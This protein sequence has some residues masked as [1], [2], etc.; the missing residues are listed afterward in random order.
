[1]R[2]NLLINPIT[3]QLFNEQDTDERESEF[4]KLFGGGDDDEKE[5]EKEDAPEEKGG[6]TRRRDP[7]GEDPASKAAPLDRTSSRDRRGIDLEG[8]PP[9]T[10]LSDIKSAKDILKYLEDEGHLNPGEGSDVIATLVTKAVS[11]VGLG[12]DFDELTDAVLAADA[13]Q[14]IEIL[15]PNLQTVTG[16]LSKEFKSFIYKGDGE[17]EFEGEL[18]QEALDDIDEFANWITYGTLLPLSIHNA[19]KKVNKGIIERAKKLGMDRDEILRIFERLEDRNMLSRA[20]KKI[21]SNLPTSMGGG[22]IESKVDKLLEKEGYDL[23]ENK[24]GKKTTKWTETLLGKYL[25]DSPSRLAYGPLKWILQGF[26]EKAASANV[27]KAFA[28]ELSSIG[29]GEFKNMTFDE[30]LEKVDKQIENLSKQTADGGSLSQDA[31]D[32]SRDLEKKK[33]LKT[34]RQQILNQLQ[35]ARDLKKKINNRLTKILGEAAVAAGKATS[36][37]LSKNK[38]ALVGY[39]DKLMTEMVVGG[40]YGIDLGPED[41]SQRGTIEKYSKRGKPVYSREYLSLVQQSR[42]ATAKRSLKSFFTKQYINSRKTKAKEM[43]E[44]VKKLLR[45]KMQEQKADG[46]VANMNSNI[47][48]KRMNQIENTLSSILQN[49]LEQEAGLDYDTTQAQLD[50]YE[51]EMELF[52]AIGKKAEEFV[53]NSIKG[54]RS[55]GGPKYQTEIDEGIIRISKKELIEVVATRINKHI[56]R[57]K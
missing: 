39:L 10:G 49:T 22:G 29:T 15:G 53:N 47:I 12:F 38:S 43:I 1:M 32:R 37:F 8:E 7:E 13:E 19:K 25:A 45:I 56:N 4:N 54:I 6:V 40:G 52:D 2:K 26:F 50:A 16:A 20:V 3:E 41:F 5:E 30:V 55:S 35:E 31:I 14:I 11:E 27:N 46:G 48:I 44:R 36:E 9:K 57:K 51:A 33:K 28:S 34:S 23:K 24:W 17:Y 21:K 42:N 18:T